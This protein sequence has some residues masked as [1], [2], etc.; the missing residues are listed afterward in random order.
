[1][2]IFNHEL[3]LGKTSL[4]IWSS[5]ISF[6]MVLCVL[7]Y[8]EMSSQI[9]EISKTFSEMGGFSQAFGMDKLNFG[10]FTG[11][12]GIEC[13]NVLGLGGAFYA[14]L[15]GVSNLAKEERNHTAEFLLTHPVSRTKVVFEKLLAMFTQILIM[16][17]IVITLSSIS[18]MIIDVSIDIYTLL[19]L[20]IAYFIMQ[21]EIGA[22]TFAIS[23]CI[24]KSQLGIGLGLATIFY[25]VNIISNLMEETKILKYFTPFGYT[26]GAEIINNNQIPIG[27]LIVGLV[28]TIISI[29]F[30][31]IKYKNKDIS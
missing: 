16:N 5:A 7:I 10:E 1:M 15:I 17:L 12:F 21:I 3:K 13:G 28:V 19:L 8:P 24:K 6:M 20:Y 18:I 23:A 11:F 25:F 30:A 26:D 2:T 14:S 9:D 27:Y 22:I 31:F 4:L 29:V